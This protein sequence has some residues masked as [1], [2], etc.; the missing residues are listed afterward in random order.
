VVDIPE[1]Q[2]LVDRVLSIHHAVDVVESHAEA[3][4][5]LDRAAE[6]GDSYEAV[7]LDINLDRSST[8]MDLLAS[9]RQHSPY[10]SI[11]AIAMT[12]FAL[13]GDRERFLKAGFDEYV[14]KPFAADQLLAAV[15]NVF[16]NSESGP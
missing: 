6:A 15:D 7:L 5:H 4:R 3:L 16:A 9:M 13:T 11:P 2:V 12:A 1:T 10:A 14:G 8:G